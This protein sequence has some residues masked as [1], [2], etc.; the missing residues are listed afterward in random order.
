M[1]NQ[2]MNQDNRNNN[3][4]LEAFIDNYGK[5]TAN[6]FVIMAGVLIVCLTLYFFFNM[7]YAGIVLF[8]IVLSWL[9]IYN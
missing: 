9:G 5:K 6:F 8:L 1:E 7:V 3:S 2:N 4:E